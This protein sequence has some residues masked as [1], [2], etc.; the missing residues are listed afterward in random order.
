MAGLVCGGGERGG[1]IEN[2]RKGKVRSRR[3]IESVRAECELIFVERKSERERRRVRES[4]ERGGGR[5]RKDLLH[6]GK[7]LSARESDWNLLGV[8]EVVE[9][10]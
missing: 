1:R 6:L 5:G 7:V 2:V 10:E 4:I 9:S 8:G 3:W